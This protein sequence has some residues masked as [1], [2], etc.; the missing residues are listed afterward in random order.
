MDIFY[1]FYILIAQTEVLYYNRKFAFGIKNSVIK[2][3]KII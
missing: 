3:G 2:N 1:I